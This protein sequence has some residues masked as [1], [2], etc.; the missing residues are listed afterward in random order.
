[1]NGGFGEEELP[2]PEFDGEPTEEEK[3]GPD[4]G[5]ANTGI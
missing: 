1:M 5:F 4:T 3:S 2:P